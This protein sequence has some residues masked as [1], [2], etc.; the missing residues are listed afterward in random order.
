MFYID[1]YIYHSTQ[2]TKMGQNVEQIY[3]LH[4]KLHGNF[5]A[6]TPHGLPPVTPFD[7]PVFFQHPSGAK[8]AIGQGLTSGETSHVSMWPE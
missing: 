4:G 5:P 8:V 6:S 3:V 1:I 2:S 7:P